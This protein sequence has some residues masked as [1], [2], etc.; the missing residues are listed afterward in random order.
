[1][2]Q[3]GLMELCPPGLAEE[4]FVHHAAPWHVIW[5]P[6][7]EGRAIRP[8]F[9]LKASGLNDTMPHWPL[10]WLPTKEDILQ[11]MYPG[12][13]IATRDLRWVWPLR[14]AHPLLLGY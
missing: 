6:G 5:K 9:D 11:A 4:D 7:K 8:I 3:H 12:C 2:E 1:M 10:T 14:C 13:H